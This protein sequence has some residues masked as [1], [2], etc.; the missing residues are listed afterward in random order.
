MP[1]Y[2]QTV[3]RDRV[4]VEV[5]VTGTADVALAGSTAGEGYQTW[6]QAFPAVA[7]N[8]TGYG[9]ADTATGDWEVGVGNYN[10]STDTLERLQV[11]SNSLGTT[12][13]INFAAGTKHVFC[14]YP[15]AMAESSAR[16]H[17]RPVVLT[18]DTSYYIRPDGN[19]AN[20]GAADTPTD[21]W[22][23]IQHAIDWIAQNVDAAGR[24][25]YIRL[26]AGATFTIPAT[27]DFVAPLNCRD[28][29]I[30]STSSTKAT[31]SIATA[32]TVLEVYP[33]GRLLFDCNLIIQYITFTTA[34]G[35][36]CLDVNRTL[37]IQ[38][39]YCEFVGFSDYAVYANDHTAVYINNANFSTSAVGTW[40]LLSA[41][42]ATA[43]YLESGALTLNSA[44]VFSEGAVSAFE[45]SKVNLLSGL[46]FIVTVTATGPRYTL[47]EN[48]N[49][50]SYGPLE[51]AIPGDAAGV[52]TLNSGFYI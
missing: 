47:K 19:D 33:E 9:V 12:A 22:L 2:R 16:E 50:Y 35:W 14:T 31:I 18:A 28:L 7:E 40:A 25:I 38:L 26:Q 17:W 27:L 6:A 37:K 13:K 39:T 34:G 29:Y 43:F 5:G 23:T 51:A 41:N 46:S 10:A 36:T 11:Y 3:F 15:A 49:I 1:D 30:Q 52:A 42:Y 32:D 4:K 48:S 8:P 20:T 21:A 24:R 45:D 44:F